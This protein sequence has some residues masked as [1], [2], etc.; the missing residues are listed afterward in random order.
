MVRMPELEHPVEDSEF[1]AEIKRD[2]WATIDGALGGLAGALTMSTL[3]LAARRAR[4][5]GRLPPERI[6]QRVFFRGL[7]QIPRQREKNALA[8]LLH[9]GFGVAGGTLFGLA[10]R[11]VLSQFNLLALSTVGTA[12]GSL[13]WLVSYM[14][15]VPVLDLLPPAHKDRTDRQIV[16]LVAH[17]IYGA[18]LGVVVGLLET[19]QQRR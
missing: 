13:I 11:R 19:N 9:I 3:M 12:Y 8:A 17:W 18:T 7:R 15:W 6:T 16:M 5:M 1:S 14:G 10:R 4:L 2:V